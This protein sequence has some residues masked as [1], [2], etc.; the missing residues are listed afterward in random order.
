MTVVEFGQGFLSMSPPTKEIERLV[1]SNTLIHPRNPEMNWCA[2]NVVIE[3]DA[4]GNIKPSRRKSS[5]KIDG[6]VALAMGIGRYMAKQENELSF[7]IIYLIHSM[8]RGNRDC[9]SC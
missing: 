7:F 1:I 6:I 2:S 3:M 4:A 5:E 9:L 8:Q